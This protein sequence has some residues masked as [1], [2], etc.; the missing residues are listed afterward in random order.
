MKRTVNIIGWDNGGGLSRDID[1]LRE[2]ASEEDVR[3]YVNERLRRAG[4]GSL[5]VRLLRR[6]RRSA[7]GKFFVQSVIGSP[8]F[9]VNVHL[10]DVRVDALWLARR[11]ILIPNQECFSGQ[12]CQSL[13]E[14]DEVWAKTRI[15][16]RIF[17]NLGC[18]VRFLGWTSVDCKIQGG[19]G[20]NSVGLHIAGASTAKGTEAVL[21]AWSRNPGWPLL[22]VLRR[23]QDYADNTLPWRERTLSE[24]I[25]IIAERIDEHELRGFQNESAFYICPSEAEGFGHVI[26]EGLSTGGIVI[27][28][29]APPMNELVTPECGLLVRVGR[30]DVLGLDYC[31]VVDLDDLELRIRAALE[32]TWEQRNNLGRAARARFEKIDQEFRLKIKECLNAVLEKSLSVPHR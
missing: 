8:P 4:Q 27:T 29:D 6:V 22:R 2:L 13:S 17:L 11:N 21:D 18:T 7:L 20:K 28:T 26:L 31:Y 30:S 24:N 5:L 32:M 12:S 14:I 3:V 19:G 9:D 1:I 15:A 25:Q 16:E 10:E 23:N